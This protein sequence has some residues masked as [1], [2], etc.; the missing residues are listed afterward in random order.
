[1]YISASDTLLQAIDSAVAAEE[2][3]IEGAYV[4]VHHLSWM[5][6]VI[7]VMKLQK[8]N[9]MPPFSPQGIVVFG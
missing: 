8:E 6:G 2:I 1:M 9:T 3:G 5:D 4:R 7:C